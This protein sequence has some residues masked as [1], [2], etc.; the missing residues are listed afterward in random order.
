MGHRCTFGRTGAEQVQVALALAPARGTCNTE[1]RMKKGGVMMQ[2]RWFA[3]MAAGCWLAPQ[4]A[5]PQA[6]ESERLV[7]PAVTVLEAAVVSVGTGADRSQGFFVAP[8]LVVTTTTSLGGRAVV[9]VMSGSG[10]SGLGQ[11]VAKDAGA[12]VAMLRVHAGLTPQSVFKIGGRTGGR[13]PAA[14]FVVR[15]GDAAD[16]GVARVQFGRVRES[17]GIRVAEILPAAAADAAGSPCVDLDGR[18]LGMVVNDD[19]TSPTGQLALV[20]DRIGTLISKAREGVEAA[21]AAAASGGAVSTPREVPDPGSSRPRPREDAD[22]ESD[23]DRAR[24]EGADAF[25]RTARRLALQRE[26]VIELQARY[27]SECV[28]TYVP[29]VTAPGVGW[30]YPVDYV[31]EKSELPECKALQQRVD[32]WSE[33]L[34]RTLADAEEQARRTGVYPG[35]VRDI[36]R[37]YGLDAVR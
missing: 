23:T 34:R 29:I 28:G 6:A 8:G 31:I 26:G 5:S 15:G 24:R 16:Q 12:D 32:D 13:L 11:V 21:E 25:E 1:T 19:P 33:S 17:R 7:P 14:G 20:T 27:D 2:T 35:T 4:T 37:A 10:R 36:K 3:L 9:Q 22:V 18:L 30:P